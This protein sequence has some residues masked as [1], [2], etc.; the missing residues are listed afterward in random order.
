MLKS[1][2][3]KQ[4]VRKRGAEWVID[5]IAQEVRDFGD[6]LYVNFQDDCFMMHSTEWIANF[7]KW[8]SRQIGVP[9][10]VRATPRNTNREKWDLLKQ[11]GLRWVFM[12]LQTGSD[13]INREVY[14]RRMSSEGFLRVAN[15]ISELKLSP[16][17]DVI[18]DNPY[19]KEVDHLQTIN[20]LLRTPRPFQLQLFSLDYFPGTELRRKAM[21]DNIPIPEIGMKSYTKPER[22]MINL[23]IRMSSTLSPRIVRFLIRIRRTMPGKILGLG[24]YGLSLLLEPFIYSHLVHKSNDFKILR[25]TKVIRKF[26]WTM[27]KK[28]FLRKHGC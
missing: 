28:V 22:K 5:E 25:T 12:G 13:R 27:I 8:Y 6:I 26:S 1:L 14:G 23:Y 9:F 21:K 16:W 10:A 24:F 18:L 20:T 3:G 19:E 7:S 2:Y 11:A 4:N 15:I 17:Y